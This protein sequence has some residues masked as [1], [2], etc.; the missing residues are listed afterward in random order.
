MATNHTTNYQLNQWEAT[1]Q[2][3][4][5][6]FNQDNAKLDAALAAHDTA[7]AGKASVT[8]LE[9][10]EEELDA[11]TAARTA[12]AA[13][14]EAKTGLHLLQTTTL[15]GPAYSLGLDPAT[16]DWT[17]WK[18]L[19]LCLSPQLEQNTTYN[20]VFNNHA[21]YRLIRYGGS[22]F[23]LQLFPLNGHSPLCSG[24]LLF[25][26]PA[27]FC[28]DFS[29]AQLTDIGIESSGGAFVAGT[30]FTVLGEK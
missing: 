2:V 21:D 15:T 1:D 27:P 18:H 20:L 6:D 24:L 30:K 26:S 28:F 22:G 3:L 29:W 16:V 8:D 4:R 23:T 7:L 14:L 9:A 17:Q 19:Y 13:Q 10:V 5:T 12:L 25:Q 11:E